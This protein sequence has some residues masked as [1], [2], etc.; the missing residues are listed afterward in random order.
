[1]Y[2]Q[3]PKTIETQD[4]EKRLTYENERDRMMAEF[5]ARGGEIK[6]Y[7][8]HIMRGDKPLGSWM[9]QDNRG[10]GFAHGNTHSTSLKDRRA[11]I[12]A[13][14]KKLIAAKKQGKAAKK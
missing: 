2:N 4:H 14:A 1:M 5:L 13:E 7:P 10:E 12:D 9:E 3:K 8:S 11:Q 6:V